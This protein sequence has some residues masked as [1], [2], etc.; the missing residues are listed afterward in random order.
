MSEGSHLSAPFGAAVV[1]G[2]ALS[3][4]FDGVLLHQILQWHHLLS[5][6][7]ADAVFSIRAQ[8]L[9]DGLFHAFMYVVALAGLILLWR[10]RQELAAP[11]GSRR[12]WSG[13]LV[14]FGAWNVLDVGLFH[15]VLGIHRVRLDVPNPIAWDTGWLIGLGLAPIALGLVLAVGRT[16]L[17]PSHIYSLLALLVLL[18]GAGLWNLRTPPPGAD[19]LVIFATTKEVLP[20]VAALDARLVQMDASGTVAVLRLSDDTAPWKLYRHGALLVQN[21]GPAGCLNWSKRSPSDATRR[22]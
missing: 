9:A 15:W 17:F 1:L 18:S 20:A 14:G 4:F 5:L 8:I 10:A 13:V 22:L 2:F 6:V 12:L 21:T 3:G 16:R 19:T 7:Q 11:N